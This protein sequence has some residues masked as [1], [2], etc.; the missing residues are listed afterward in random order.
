M[1]N[2]S[3]AL[4]PE[5]P[6]GTTGRSP[7]TS[8]L[9]GVVVIDGSGTIES[10]SSAA[11]RLLGVQTSEVSGRS[12]DSLIR[13]LDRDPRQD[14]LLEAYRTHG[15]SHPALG[16][17]GDGSSVALKLE[18]STLRLEPTPLFLCTI[19]DVEAGAPSPASLSRLEELAH[20]NRLSAVENMTAALAHEISQPL[21]AIA[22]QA[23]ICQRLLESDDADDLCEARVF[24]RQIGQHGQRAARV[25]RSMRGY[26]RKGKRL[27]RKVGL[28]A[29]V[30]TACRL[31]DF[32]ARSVGAVLVKEL[33]RPL[34]AVRVDP[35]QIEQVIF[36]L[37]RNALEALD[38]LGGGLRRE[39]RIITR[40][41]RDGDS[42]AVEFAAVDCGP[43]FGE[44]DP[45]QLF[46]P[47]FTTKADGMG[48]G[49]PICRA[50]ID[51]HGG[52]LWAS[53]VRPTGAC[54]RFRLPAAD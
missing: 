33:S 51:A 18:F 28:N 3:A 5:H 47:H 2:Q 19:R 16:R 4:P 34:P 46:D 30:D 53:A 15:S 10:M 36:N 9:D 48:L 26:L 25:V 43:G 20:S 54:F 41:H 38:T 27:H 45:E 24:L 50:I 8:E 37:A 13:L 49:L 6:T 7:Q 31:I 52:R 29:I 35:V 40:L 17:R 11:E 1:P 32:E 21:T 44:R 39:L 22:L 12:F 42:R 23:G 14:S